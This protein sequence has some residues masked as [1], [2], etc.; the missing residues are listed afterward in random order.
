MIARILAATFMLMMTMFAGWYFLVGIPATPALAPFDTGI[1]LL[2]AG[3]ALT[4][5]VLV[6]GRQE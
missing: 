6:F 5:F 2:I 4:V 1:L 3:F